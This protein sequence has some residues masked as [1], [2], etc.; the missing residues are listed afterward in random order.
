MYSIEVCVLTGRY[1]ATTPEDP[2]VSE[3]PPHPVRLFYAMIDA[4]SVDKNETI[5]EALE[6]LESQPPPNITASEADIRHGYVSYVPVN[7][8]VVISDRPE[9]DNK[10]EQISE[11]DEQ[12]QE[13]ASTNGSPPIEVEGVLKEIEK[14]QDISEIEITPTKK[15]LAK[16]RSLLEN[17]TKKARIFTS[18]SPIKPYFTFTWE[19]KPADKLAEAIDTILQSVTRIGHSSSFVYCRTHT[20]P[21]EATYVPTPDSTEETISLRC[22][23]PGLFNDLKTGY[24][25][26]DKGLSPRKK[27]LP[28][29]PVK[30]INVK[31]VDTNT[32]PI[33]RTEAVGYWDVY[34]LENREICSTKTFALTG[35][36]RSSIFKILDTKFPEG[37]DTMPEAIT[38]H[39][40]SD[41]SPSKSLHIGFYALPNVGHRYSDGKVMGLAINIPNQI[42]EV[43]KKILWDT[44]KSF[45]ENPVI[46]FDG[47]SHKLRSVSEGA[48]L[49]TLKTRTWFSPSKTWTTAIPIF[50]T[51]HN[52]T[53]SKGAPDVIERR[54][55]KLREL[56]G[57]TCEDVGLPRPSVVL[58]FDP[59]IYGAKANNRYDKGNKNWGRVIHAHMVFEETI[60]GPVV[61][62][63]GRYFGAGLMYPTKTIGQAV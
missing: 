41:G 2:K 20:N 55:E 63:D 17:K 18:A 44:L 53:L 15:T 24:E 60:S 40:K 50:L 21:I 47:M 3:W 48:S 8:E 54:W 57:D 5:K 29:N 13:I 34:E 9:V 37:R 30:Y 7:D 46:K 35:A 42:D 16:A 36:L 32:Q 6:W 51:K 4:W 1:V 10:F 59:F 11:L 43:S 38:G 61:L 33:I 56:V 19:T 52:G 23:Y 12:L 28:H 45:K 62:G 39:T 27:L 22:L 31:N 26:F 25:R 14:I 49:E 58:S